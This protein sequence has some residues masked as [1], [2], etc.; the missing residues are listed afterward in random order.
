[1]PIDAAL[2]AAV[3][4][5]PFVPY[6]PPQP[7]PPG[8]C[9]PPVGDWIGH[10]SVY[11]RAQ[12]GNFTR[13]AADV[14]W[15]LASTAGC[16]DRYVP[17]GTV[18]VDRA[19]DCCHGY[20]GDASTSIGPGDGE[21]IV[22]RSTLPPTYRMR[23]ETHWDLPQSCP[24]DAANNC[25]WGGPD[26]G[27]VWASA[28]GE[29]PGD[30]LAGGYG[31]GFPTEVD[32]SFTRV[33]A[34]LPTTPCSTAAVDR[35]S[36]IAAMEP[37]ARAE[38]NW[39][40]V[41]TVGCRDTYR[42]SGTAYTL[43]HGWGD[44]LWTTTPDA[45]PVD[46]SG[47]LVIDRSTPVP[48]FSLSGITTWPAAIMCHHPDGSVTTQSATATSR[49]GPDFRGVVLGDRFAGATDVDGTTCRWAAHR[50]P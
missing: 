33:G 35:W 18:S 28:E 6:S 34:T 3:P 40:R 24:I 12:S 11:E 25:L 22:D 14:T 38:L 42:A 27:G 10:A 17:R 1:M 13:H 5:A 19:G 36:G 30:V 49:W 37:F 7:L 21:L 26:A 47:E 8:V 20:A 48:T 44:C 16:V 2:D 50:L 32:W 29:V 41:S 15:T 43:P 31:Q 9:A 4:V 23:G 46:G 39:T 45:S